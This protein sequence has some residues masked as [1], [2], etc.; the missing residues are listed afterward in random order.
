MNK[1]SANQYA[2]YH[3]QLVIP[4]IGEEGQQKLSGAS[5]LVVGTGG[6]G[7]PV[8]YYLAAAGVGRIGLID[9][10]RVELSNLQRQ[11]LH[12]TSDLGVM[13]VFSA[14]LKLED[15]NPEIKVVAYPQRLETAEETL[16]IVS[17]FDVVV[18]AVDNYQTRYLLN[19]A[20]VALRKPLV[21]GGVLRWEGMV[22]TI[23][24]GQ[25]PCYRCVFPGP[26]AGESEA[27][28]PASAG[29]VGAVPGVMGALQ[30]IEVLKLITGAGQPLVSRLLVY[31]GLGAT[32]TEAEIARNPACPICGKG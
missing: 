9:S 21:E 15:L 6:L 5:V 25:G 30:A 14:R 20:C 13:K 19:D 12:F 23:L 29:V 8:A 7:S 26:M 27:T 31:D 4:E 22:M 32:F 3:R 17:K 2:R 28:R 24:P 16:E 10:D 1:L 18:G 11:I